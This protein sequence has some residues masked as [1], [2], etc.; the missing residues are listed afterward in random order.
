MDLFFQ[1]L[2]NQIGF[3]IIMISR[4]AINITKNTSAKKMNETAQKTSY[5]HKF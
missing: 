4:E 2:E 1:N 3:L 5:N